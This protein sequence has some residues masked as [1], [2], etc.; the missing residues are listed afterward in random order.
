MRRALIALLISCLAGC[1]MAASASASL[2]TGTFLTDVTVS[3]PS[4]LSPTSGTTLTYPDD[5]FNLSWA[6]VA[7]AGKY[8]LFIARQTSSSADC[9]AS[10]AFAANRIIL[11]K[12]VDEPTYVPTL[13]SGD[14]D[15][16]WTGTYCWKVRAADA[17]DGET[18]TYLYGFWSSANK[19]IR[20]WDATPTNLKFFDDTTG[21]IP[22]SSEST[23]AAQSSTKI[24]GYLYW[25]DVDGAA[26]Y[27]VQVSNSISFADD[28]VVLTRTSQGNR[29]ALLHL[30]DDTYF[31]RV[32]AIDPNGAEGPWK[33]DDS[34]VFSVIWKST[35][36]NDDANVE[37]NDGGTYG[38]MTIGWTPMPGASYYEVQAASR[39]GC[40]WEDPESTYL[41]S[42]WGHW[43]TLRSEIPIPPRLDECRL[44]P[45]HSTTINNFATV[46]SL[47]ADEVYDAIEVWPPT[48]CVDPDTG[49]ILCYDAGWPHSGCFGMPTQ[50]S[51]YDGPYTTS[52]GVQTLNQAMAAIH[53]C[54]LAQPSRIGPRVWWRVRPVY[55]LKQETESG[56]LVNGTHTVHGRW[57]DH[58]EGSGSV[59]PRH[60]L[61]DSIVTGISAGNHC[62]DPMN[63]SNATND[64]CLVHDTNQVDTDRPTQMA[65]DD[66]AVDDS[67]SLQWPIFRFNQFPGALGYLIQVSRDPDFD[68]IH[69][70]R[71]IPVRGGFT[72]D[73]AMTDALPDNAEGTGY[74]WR[75]IPMSVSPVVVPDTESNPATWIYYDAAPGTYLDKSDGTGS[76]TFTRS[77]ELTTELSSDF[78]GNTPLIKMYQAGA[79]TD[80]EKAIGM[81]GA[82]HYEI[83]M[84]TDAFF[85]SSDKVYTTT[86]PRFVPYGKIDDEGARTELDDGNWY[87]RVR[88]VDAN[89]LTGGWS[90]NGS[91]A[92]VT[93][94][95]VIPGSAV[96]QTSPDARATW[97]PVIGAT[98]YEMQYSSDSTFQTDINKVFTRQTTALID[99]ATG[100]WYWRVRAVVDSTDGE[101]TDVDETGPYVII[102]SRSRIMFDLSRTTVPAGEKVFIDG[103]LS[104]NGMGDNGETLQL[105]KKNAVCGQSGTYST[106]DS[107]VTGSTGEEGTVRIGLLV[108]RN[109]CY[110]WAWDYGSGIMYSA[111]ISV[112]SYPKTTLKADRKK[113]RRGKNFAVTV[114]SNM[115]ITGRVRVQYN[116]R[117]TW[118]TIKT[119][120]YS[121]MKKYKFSAQ[122]N[123]SGNFRLRAV[124]D[125]L[126]TSAGDTAY[127]DSSASGPKIRVNDLW[128]AY[129]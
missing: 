3:T 5:V 118:Y 49:A 83:Q 95:P 19:L 59:L 65:A 69:I 20:T 57:M 51:E 110:R 31:W 121:D 28:S 37:P 58:D 39:P 77:S 87:F 35:T 62:W 41:P 76:Q 105:Q 55:E 92:K 18:V 119:A 116:R 68:T 23:A 47:I 103:F 45:K 70:V 120:T 122:I 29:V 91:F 61:L 48:D 33:D 66:T 100:T 44:S 60:F 27:E 72:K 107:Q 98:S 17:V 80:A 16:L 1:V 36:W 30:P 46:Q 2:S 15:K 106:V 108:D 10:S 52:T 53:P 126:V 94:A 6:S 123:K 21:S 84:S 88:A 104:T 43:A 42:Y 102:S 89:G 24:A 74:W 115:P 26:T 79:S 90:D 25:D 73:Y 78:Q 63:T 117:G 85:N 7:G 4:G 22:R 96:T 101:W 64:G 71:E 14:G 54:D 11:N 111:P 81:D 50:P 56:W 38:N 86:I 75:A 9:S 97:N 32:R 128:A 99:A 12:I 82:D 114:T 113:V 34:Q 13:L 129:L 127:S 93:P 124:F 112:L 67:T 40:F 8:Q 109:R 125:R